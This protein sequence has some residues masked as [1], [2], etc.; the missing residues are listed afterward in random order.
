MNTGQQARNRVCQETVASA[1]T[2]TLQVLV[3][4]GS[5]GTITVAGVGPSATEHSFIVSNRTMNEKSP[6]AYSERHGTTS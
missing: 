5:H 6:L 1:D 2:R 3:V 4:N